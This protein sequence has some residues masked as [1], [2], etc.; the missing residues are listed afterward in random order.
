MRRLIFAFTTGLMLV[1]APAAFAQTVGYADAIKILAAS[2]GKD[3]ESYCKSATLANNGITQ[4][5][6]KNQSK[7][8]AKCNSDRLVVISLIQ[9]RLAAQ[10]EAPKLCQRDAAQY[11]KGVKAGA[12]HLLRCL[13]KAQPSV[14]EKCNTAIDLA[15]YR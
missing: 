11:C 6:E 5:L 3:I 12:G 8:S 2:C 1:A 4:C 7:L 14:S 13:L 9:A 10:A 15:G